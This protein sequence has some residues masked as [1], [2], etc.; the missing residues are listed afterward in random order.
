MV[1]LVPR[2]FGRNFG[3]PIRRHLAV[4][5]FRGIVTCDEGVM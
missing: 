1:W 5:V 4:C 2:D 3:C